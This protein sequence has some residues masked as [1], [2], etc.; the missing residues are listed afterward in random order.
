M[1][2]EEPEQPQPVSIPVPFW[3]GPATGLGD[4]LK[5]ATDQMGIQPCGG[6]EQRRQWLNRRIQLTGWE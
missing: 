5:A 4:A 1:Y 6:C 3:N 2:I